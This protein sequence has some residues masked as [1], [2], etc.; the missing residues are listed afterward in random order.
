MFLIL[1]LLL[2]GMGAGYALRH[3]RGVQRVEQSTRFTI[4]L[5]LFTFGVSIGSNRAL[6]ADIMQ[7]GWRAVVISLLGVAGSVVAAGVFQRVWKNSGGK[8]GAA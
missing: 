5:L 2:L 7:L 4:W 3:V 6:I 8:G 1:S